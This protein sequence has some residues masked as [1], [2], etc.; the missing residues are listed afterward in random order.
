ME[1]NENR[2][3]L[4]GLHMEK[5]QANTNARDHVSRNMT[6]KC[7]KGINSFIG[8][9]LRSCSITPILPFQTPNVLS[10]GADWTQPV[11]QLTSS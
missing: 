7:Y 8:V 4:C 1:R 6:I 3:L 10:H 5:A 11:P 2:F 9:H